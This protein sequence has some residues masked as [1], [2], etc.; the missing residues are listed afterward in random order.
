[1]TDGKAPER[2]IIQLPEITRIEGHAAVVVDIEESGQCKVQLEVFE[3]TRFFERIVIGHHYKEL[4]HITSRV[5][6][7]CST[8]HVLAACRAV[9]A[10]LSSVV[11]SKDELLFRELLHLGMIIESHATHIFALALPDFIGVRD[12]AEFASA[13]AEHFTAWIRLRELGAAI[14]TCV[15]GRPFH[16]VALQVGGFSSYPSGQSLSDIYKKIQECDKLA[17]AICEFL[18]QI[19]VGFGR[20]TQPRFLALIPSD[21]HYG[22]FG[23]RVRCSEGWESDISEYRTY[24]SE[25][26]VPYSHAKRADANGPPIMVG[27]MTRLFLYHDKLAARAGELYKKSPLA[28]GDHNSVWNNLAQSIELVEALDRAKQ[29][30]EVLLQS[31]ELGRTR[32][33]DLPSVRESSSGVGAVECPRG[34]LYHSYSLSEKGQVLQADMITPSVQNSARIELDIQEVVQDSLD[35]QAPELQS[36]LETLVRAYD[37]CNTCATHMVRIRYS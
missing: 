11:Q 22:Y 37:P 13:H 31:Q 5:C 36:Q 33:I 17:V 4:P 1:M 15:G 2:K 19:K 14:Q 10:A 6:A 25:K 35:Y 24:L 27:S 18:L 20:R 32:H 12:L 3:G 7:I 23:D 26:V 30:I 8:G 9:E 34:T 21:K 29:L 16:P 28:K